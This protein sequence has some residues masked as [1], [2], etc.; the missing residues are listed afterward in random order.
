MLQGGREPPHNHWQCRVH[1]V[2]G[3]GSEAAGGD[4]RDPSP[5]RQVPRKTSLSLSLSLIDSSLLYLDR[6]PLGW[7]LLIAHC[8][9]EGM[10][11]LYLFSHII[12]RRLVT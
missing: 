4:A 9:A 1:M 6:C 3:T 5:G 8:E 11:P 7:P 10:L 2:V 12:L